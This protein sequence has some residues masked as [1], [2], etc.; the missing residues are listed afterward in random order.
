MPAAADVTPRATHSS[1]RCLLQNFL[2]LAI[3]ALFIAYCYVTAAV[4]HRRSD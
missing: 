3:A 1:P 2:G 4:P